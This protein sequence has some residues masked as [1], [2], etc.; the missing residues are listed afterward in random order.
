MI[1]QLLD[2]DYFLNGTKPVLRLYCKN[3]SGKSVCFFYDRFLPYFYVRKTDENLK[4]VEE[5]GVSFSIEKKFLPVGY[6]EEPTNLIKITLNDPSTVPK[7]REL[8]S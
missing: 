1:V 7:I 5:L 3:E 2:V 4:K 8:F 6:S